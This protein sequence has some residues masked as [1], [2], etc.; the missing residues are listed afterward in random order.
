MLLQHLPASKLLFSLDGTRPLDVGIILD[1]TLALGADDWR[2]V[3]DFLKRVVNGLGVSSAPDGARV[4]L[5]RF[6][7]R[8]FISLYF[9]TIRDENLTPDAVNRFIDPVTQVQGERRI[10]LALQRAATV[11]FTSR[12]GSR[13]NA[14][15]VIKI[16]ENGLSYFNKKP[17]DSLFSHITPQSFYL[18]YKSLENTPKCTTANSVPNIIHLDSSH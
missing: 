8:P 17:A 5:L 9:N 1:Q 4:G 12:G 18:W 13:P 14:K 3:L 2:A 11:L 16:T 6:T 7:S 15:K 10:D